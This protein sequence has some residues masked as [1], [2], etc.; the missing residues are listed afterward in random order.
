MALCV[1]ID[2]NGLGPRLGP[3][4]VTAVLARVAPGAEQIVRRAPSGALGRRLGDS[5][6]LVAHGRTA[7]AEAWARALAARG[8][9][10]H[11]R[12][13][14]PAELLRSL[15]LDDEAALREPCP[16]HAAAQ[17]WSEEGEAFSAAADGF[18]E[19]V[20]GDLRALAAQGVQPVAVR[21]VLVC[22]RSLNRAAAEGRSR[23]DEDLHAMERLV[24]A[25]REL[26]GEPV[27]AVC[28]KVGGRHDYA[29]ALGPL[30]GRQCTPIEQGPARSA[31]RIAGVGEVAFARDADASDLLVG[32]ASLVGKYLRELVMARVV[33]YYRRA[34]PELPDAS[35]YWDP[36]TARFVRDSEPVRRALALPDACF[37]RGRRAVP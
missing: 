20:Q 27:C 11:E 36:V 32:L 25:M 29:S 31:Y 35:G 10:R 13:S 21:S 12:C 14:R 2:E 3:L 7:I 5:K 28:G 22:A 17:C 8:A 37:E 33:R 18:L 16:A 24:L 4:V 30:A 23:F 19:E 15:L 1:G 34:V 9:G 6:V 26:A